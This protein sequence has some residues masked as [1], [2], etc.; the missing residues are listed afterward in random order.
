MKGRANIR[1]MDVWTKRNA[2]LSNLAP[3][4]APMKNQSVYPSFKIVLV[5]DESSF[6]TATAFA[7]KRE[8]ITNIETIEDSRLVLESIAGGG[9]GIL[10]LDMAMPYVSG[11]DI[12][13]EVR[14]EYPEIDVFM[15]TA[16][17][18]VQ[19]A[20]D[21]LKL[22]A[23]DY[24]VKPI[25]QR[26]IAAVLKNA[27]ESR[28]LMEEASRLKGSLLREELKHPEAFSPIITNDGQM[29]NIFKY[30][31]VIA[32]VDVPVLITGETGTGK[33][34]VA[35]AI[36]GLSGRNG[37]FVSTNTAGIDDAT[38]SDTL[39]GHVRG[40]FTGADRN[41]K[42]LV[43]EAAHGTLF[44][45]EI[46]DLRAESQTKLL[47]FLEGGNYRPLGSD[48]VVASS[49]RLVFAT[50]RDLRAL[51]SGGQFRPD[52]YYRLQSH[53]VALPPLRQRMG[54]L[55]H[56]TNFFVD[57]ASSKFK[58]TRP[59]LNPE[60]YSLLTTYHWPGNVRELRGLLFDAVSRNETHSLSLKHLK[61]R[62][63]EIRNEIPAKD[64]TPERR[65]PVE[66][67]QKRVVFSETLPTADELELLLIHEALRRTGGNKTQAADLIGLARGTVIKRLK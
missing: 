34:L 56:L 31:E 2:L 1:I 32:E 48:S 49:A 59:F 67:A 29:R 11:K 42:G 66:A 58:R 27:V 39:F 9:C 22:G 36:H 12:L 44:L 20:I 61:S 47:R 16:I 30:I 18:D 33:E 23:R 7:L 51:A 46:G 8:G 38:F 19:N 14:R 15:L 3:S 60:V 50:N 41:R 17:R 37:A 43:E 13:V 28:M 26:E 63:R 53:E 25:E 52:L 62:L 57:E 6:L 64:A 45:D 40:A 65:E 35:R 5:D 24:L 4:S 10:V 21:C 55:V 54:D